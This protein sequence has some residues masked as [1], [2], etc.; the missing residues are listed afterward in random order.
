MA[1]CTAA[2]YATASSGLMLLLRS[3]PLK[4]SCSSFCTLG[5]RVE[6]PTRTRSWIC[7]LSSLASRRAFSTGS[8]VLRN[9]SEHSSSN[10][11]LVMDV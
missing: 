1:A 7:A 11:A 2:P 9:R 6:P 8:R 3:R 4:K 5:M 10:R